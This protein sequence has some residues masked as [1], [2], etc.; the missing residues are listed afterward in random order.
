MGSSQ[1]KLYLK[2][3]GVQETTVPL[4]ST[5]VI[6][7]LMRLFHLNSLMINGLPRS[8]LGSGELSESPRRF[9]Q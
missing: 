7:L 5:E 4:S 6:T 2:G 3:N 1:C 9:K 8:S